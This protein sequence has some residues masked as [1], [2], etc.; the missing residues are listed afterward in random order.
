M[1][2]NILTSLFREIFD[3]TLKFEGKCN[4]ACCSQSEIEKK[5]KE[6]IYMYI[7][8]YIRTYAF[9]IALWEFSFKETNE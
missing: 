1:H 8:I 4:E 6:N 7:Y 3:Y 5:Q 2:E 9:K